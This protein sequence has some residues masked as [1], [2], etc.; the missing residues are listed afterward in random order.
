LTLSNS[1]L[2][3]GAGSFAQIGS[4]KTILAAANTYLGGTT[5]SSGTLWVK[6]TQ[7]LGTGGVTL[8]NGT[9]LVSSQQEMGGNLQVGGNFDWTDG[10][11]A[12]YDTG[13]SPG[14]GDLTIGVN[15][16]FTASRAT[17]PSI[18]VGWRHWMPATTRWSMP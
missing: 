2:I 11:I 15:G 9:L 10:K 13:A 7:A 6:A 17:R 16:T 4:N 14:S 1:T 5:I 8:N 18:S 3:T 12:F